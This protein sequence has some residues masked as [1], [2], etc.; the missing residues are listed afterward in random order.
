MVNSACKYVLATDF[1]PESLREEMSNVVLE[2]RPEALSELELAVL[3]AY[4]AGAGQVVLNLD[5]VEALDTDG[6]RG[7][8]KLLRSSRAV[9]GELALR[10]TKAVVRRTLAVTALDRLFPMI[11]EVAA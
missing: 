2:Y 5:S 6:V 11:E 10:A 1:S 9:G 8:I 4:E 3:T 7:L